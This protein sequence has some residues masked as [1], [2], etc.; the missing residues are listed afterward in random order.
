MLDKAID[1]YI[2]LV[3]DIKVVN[4]SW[5]N[6][7]SGSASGKAIVRNNSKFSVPKLKYKVTFKDGYGNSIT[8]EDGYVTYG[9][10]EPGENKSFS[11][12][13]SY[14]GGALRATMDLKFDDDLIYE[15]LA[16]KA[17]T[18]K[19]CDE[20]FKKHTKNEIVDSSVIKVGDKK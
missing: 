4:F 8:S 3:R 16:K 12:Y 13:S 14:V 10:L 5:E 7:Y 1:V 15:Y 20:Y 18:G 9:V 2:E 6:L 11:F 17:W 19:E